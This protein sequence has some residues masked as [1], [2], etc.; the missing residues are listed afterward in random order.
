MHGKN[1]DTPDRG[2]HSVQESLESALK[3]HADVRELIPEFYYCPEMFSN[4]N[5][6]RFGTKQDG[7]VV[8]DVKL[9]AWCNNDPHLFVIFLREAFESNYVSQN[10]SSWI[11]FIFGFKQR[12]GEAEKSLNLFS[13]LTY[14]DGIDID[15][16]ND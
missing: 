11:D 6:I 10:I 1:L 13:H 4:N 14:E 5:K 16:I 8:D 7:N 12:D 9:P 3:D 2:F 15:S